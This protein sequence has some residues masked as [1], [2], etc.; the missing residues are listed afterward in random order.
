MIGSDWDVYAFNLHP[1]EPGTGPFP[2]LPFVRTWWEERRPHGGELLIA[3]SDI[4]LV[5]FVLTDGLVTIAGDPDVTDY[6]SPLGAGLAML[7]EELAATVPPGTQF[8]LDSLPGRA[9]SGLNDAL[10]DNG[11]TPHGAVHE[12]AAVLE[13]PDT[14]DDYLAALSKKERHET[15]RKIRRFGEALGEPR[16]V[17]YKGADAV[18]RFAEM[19]RHSS[20]DKG[21]FMTTSMESFFLALHERADAIIDVLVG[22]EDVPAAAAFGFEDDAAYYLYNSAYEPQYRDSSPG[23]VLLAKLIEQAID[24]GRRTF[25]FLKGDEAYKFRLGATERPLCRLSGVFTRS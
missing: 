9:S 3:S 10:L 25:D 14:F 23:V 15:R 24:S 11:F 5:P 17:R 20:G 8:D 18:G 13:L 16:V 4:G 1:L 6:H 19:H 2:E 7:I 12:V 21:E 22:D